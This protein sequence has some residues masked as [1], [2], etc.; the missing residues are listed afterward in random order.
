[1]VPCQLRFFLTKELCQLYIAFAVLH[2]CQCSIT[3]RERKVDP[4]S[5]G[6]NG[7]DWSFTVCRNHVVVYATYLCVSREL[8]KGSLCS[9]AICCTL[10][11]LLRRLFGFHCTCTGG[12]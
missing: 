8:V 5:L 4:D 11:F 1:M 2:L 9:T 7:N 3:N 12:F 6:I 10:K